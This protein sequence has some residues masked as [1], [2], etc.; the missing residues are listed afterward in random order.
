MLSNVFGKQPIFS[1]LYSDKIYDQE[2]DKNLNVHC[3]IYITYL[4]SKQYMITR[5]GQKSEIP[6]VSCSYNST[7]IIDRLYIY[8]YISGIPRII[9]YCNEKYKLYHPGE[10]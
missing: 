8:L 6:D 1:I 3:L 7:I 10:T 4:L 9:S 2:C 5:N